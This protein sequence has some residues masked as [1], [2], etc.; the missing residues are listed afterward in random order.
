MKIFRERKA[1]TIFS[2]ISI[3]LFLSLYSAAQETNDSTEV[4]TLQEIENLFGASVDLAYVG[5]N[6]WAGWQLSNGP[7]IQPTFK[8]S[9]WKFNIG[10]YM[11]LY[12][13]ERDWDISSV[14]GE[15]IKGQY[16]KGFGM[17]DEVQFFVDGGYDWKYFSIAAAYWHLSYTWGYAQFTDPTKNKAICEWFGVLSSGELTISPAVHLGPFTIFT[18]QNL[19]IAAESRDEQNTTNNALDSLGIVVKKSGLWDYHGVLGVSWSKE[20]AEGL[21]IELVAKTEWASKKFIEPWLDGRLK[22][23][24]KK[25]NIEPW[26]IYHITV[27]TSSSYSILPQLSVSGYF[28]VEFITNRWVRFNEIKTIKGCIPYAG[29]NLSYSWSW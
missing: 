26:G 14:T 27:G 23:D 25:K 16:K 13:S 7:C 9:I 2:I 22:S 6:M 4:S 12:G 18:D 17:C 24:L 19:V 3:M 10:I 29:I 20:A 11:N 28:N 21:S 5:P 8:F 1:K 15:G